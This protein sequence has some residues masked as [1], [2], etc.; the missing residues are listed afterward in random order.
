MQARE[1]DDLRE[2]LTAAGDLRAALSDS[3][4]QVKA[5]QQQIAQ[6]DTRSEQ[7][8]AEERAK[9]AAV[10]ASRERAAVAAASRRITELEANIEELND[11]VETLTLDK[12]QQSLEKE[13]ALELV[14]QLQCELEGVKLD[15]EHAALSATDTT[16]SATTAAGDTAAAAAASGGGVSEGSSAVAAELE[17]VHA[18]NRQLKEALKRLHDLSSADKAELGKKVSI[19]HHAISCLYH[20]TMK[21]VLCLLAAW[22]VAALCNCSAHRLVS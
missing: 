18:Q 11:A 17:L 14:E 9:A 19:D 15:L 1:V 20:T 12:E 8:L 6:A 10:A 3:V 16:T 5:L 13:E 21:R 22:L 2:K 4:S 7:S